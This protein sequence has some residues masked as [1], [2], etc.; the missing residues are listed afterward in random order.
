MQRAFD[1]ASLNVTVIGAARS[2][3]A[4]ARLLKRK[5]V[6]VFLTELSPEQKYPEAARIMREEGIPF[7]FGEHGD[8]VF[9]SDLIVVSPGVPSDAPVLRMA[10][11]LGMPVISEIEVGA[12]FL[13]GPIIAITGTNGKT[14][15]T[16]LTGD[17]CLGARPRSLVAGN[18]GTAF[19]DAIFHHEGPIEMAVLEISSF[20]LDTCVTFHPT[21]SVI[22]TITPDHLHRY[23][24]SF[25]EYVSSKER[26]FMNQ[27]PYD[28]LVYNYDD[29]VVTSAIRTARAELFPVS[30]LQRLQLGGWCE[31]GS[32]VMDAGHGRE[33]V[34]LVK[35]L[36]VH[37]R[38]NHM[39]V[40]MSALAA[41]LEGIA[42][43]VIQRA[44]TAFKGVE[45]RLE[46]VCDLDGIKWIND[47]KA[48]NVDSVVIALN[49]YKN[50]VVLIAGGRDKGTSYSPLV[51]IVKDRVRAMVLIGEAAERMEAVFAPVTRVTRARDMR[52]AVNIARMAA[53]PGDIAML[54][55]A[56]ASFD[57]YENFEQR[58]HDFKECVHTFCPEPMVV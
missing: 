44:V 50:P 13:D 56:C 47:S 17:I 19:T 25:Q 26:V 49:S 10:E 6:T 24:G 39:N 15:V 28:H 41:R 14:T 12:M 30:S 2:G 8:H 52:E 31:N 23:H 43:D 58:G 36:Q 57:M 1:I 27:G 9:D 40:L 37:G 20:Q 38:H 29:P 45:H 53:Q 18:I 35:D 54:S 48:T 5:G 32:L 55:P 4:A 42:I 21:T 16:T 22:T 11:R 34:A 51:D 46:F 3:L 33:V 7:E